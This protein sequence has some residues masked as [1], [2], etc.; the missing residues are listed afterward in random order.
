MKRSLSRTSRN[1]ASSRGISG[2]YSARTSTS[3]IVC[4]RAHSSRGHPPVDQIRHEEH[5]ACNDR[6]FGVAEAVIEALIAGAEAVAGAGERERP[7]R[8]TGEREEQVRRERHLEDPG[9]DRDER[10]DDGRDPA[11]EDAPVPPAVEPRLGAGETLRRDVEPT[12]A[13]LEQGPSPV[14]PDRPADERTR[15]VAQRAR[16]GKRDE[17]PGAEADPRAEEGHP[18]RGGKNARG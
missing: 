10:A 3:G 11:D 17:G 1:A 6:I 18:V 13:A 14:A 4:I 5:D 9:G 8:G 2:S 16:E 12:A 15:E 7:H